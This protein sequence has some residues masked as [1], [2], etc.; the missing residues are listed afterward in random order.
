VERWDQTWG[1]DAPCV[2]HCSSVILRTHRW[3]MVTQ[4]LDIR[5]DQ[6]RRRKLRELASEQG[7]SVSGL[8]RRLIDRAYADTIRAAASARRM[9]WANW[10]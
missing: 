3:I 4:R 10:R 9:S 1:F 2:R 7:D 8:N 5:L 6:Q